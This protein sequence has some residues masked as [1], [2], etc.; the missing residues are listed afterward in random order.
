MSVD[1]PWCGHC[2]QFEPVY[3]EAAG[4]LKDEEPGMRL[5]KVD[6]IEERE[7]AD[8]FEVGSFPTLKMFMNGDRKKP[9]DY[10]GRHTPT[11][12]HT[13]LSLTN[14]IEIKF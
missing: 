8:E 3:A 7:L 10:S 5:A 2:K 13:Q 14:H 9:V 4:K 1:A 11:H 6:A 12:T